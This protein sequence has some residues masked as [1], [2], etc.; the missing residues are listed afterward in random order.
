[1]TVGAVTSIVH[2]VVGKDERCTA[3]GASEMLAGSVLGAAHN[4]EAAFGIVFSVT[5][6]ACGR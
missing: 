5:S 3:T 2:E 1:M 4:V 6:P